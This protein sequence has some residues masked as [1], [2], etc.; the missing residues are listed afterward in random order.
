M[1]RSPVSCIAT[2]LLAAC[3][4]HTEAREPEDGAPPAGETLLADAPPGWVRIYSTDAANLKLVEY[5]APDSPAD[6]WTDKLTFESLAGPSLPDPAAFLNSM[7]ADQKLNCDHSRVKETFSGTENGYPSYVRYF[8]CDRNK[9]LDR[10]QVTMIKVIQGNEQLYT[11]SRARR[12]A[13]FDMTA[14]ETAGV[15]AEDIRDWTLHL[16]AISVCDTN[17]DAHPC[18][19]REE[20]VPAP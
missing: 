6:D 20:P 4:P 13:A 8:E 14:D 5:V 10:G 7:A 19:Q 2:L 1:Y 3:N 15:T 18:P 12:V 9:L 16:R 11:I 17:R